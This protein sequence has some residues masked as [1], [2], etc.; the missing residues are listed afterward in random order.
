MTVG[1]DCANPINDRAPKRSAE[2]PSH[3]APVRIN[4]WV[5]DEVSLNYGHTDLQI[6]VTADLGPT[7]DWSDDHKTDQIKAIPIKSFLV[8]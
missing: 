3:F 2:F 5:S 4:W 1:S 7:P 8:G 6:I